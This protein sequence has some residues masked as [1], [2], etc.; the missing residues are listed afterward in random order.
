MQKLDVMTIRNV[1]LTRH[2][3]ANI[4]HLRSLQVLELT[5]HESSNLDMPLELSTLKS[6][7]LVSDRLPLCTSFLLLAITPQLSNIAINYTRYAAPAEVGEFVLSLHTSCRS[8]A[9]LEDIFVRH[10]FLFSHLDPNLPS[11]LPSHLFRPLLRFRRLKTVKFIAMGKYCF[12]DAFIE[13]AAVAWP[14]IQEL[15]FTSETTD[16]TMV[17]FGAMLSLAS[18]CRSLRVLHLTFDATQRPTLSHRT[19]IDDAPNGKQKLWPKQPALQTL[20]VGHSKV[21]KVALAP[22]ILAMVFPNLVDILSFETL[23]GSDHVAWR[24]VA[25]AVRDL[26]NLREKDP[27]RSASLLNPIQCI[28]EC[29]LP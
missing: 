20:H 12:D 29:T 5:L 15:W 14:D 1:C 22:F 7:T 11:P 28:L 26:V 9:S 17:S 10:Y 6:L 8:F 13:D 19:D 23:G 16:T 21:S 27:V 24:Q 3:M 4:G 25:G 18:Q 2:S